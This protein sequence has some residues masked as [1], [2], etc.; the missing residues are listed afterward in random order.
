MPISPV[1][2]ATRYLPAFRGA[3]D[4]ILLVPRKQIE[5]LGVLWFAYAMFLQYVAGVLKIGL[6]LLLRDG[7]TSV[8]RFHVATNVEA[9]STRQRADLIDEQLPCAQ[10]RIETAA[11]TEATE[12]GIGA[13]MSLALMRLAGGRGKSI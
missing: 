6:P 11:H 2:R 5:K 4:D 10:V 3:F 13:D 9:R 8:R 12:P 7:Q 1:R